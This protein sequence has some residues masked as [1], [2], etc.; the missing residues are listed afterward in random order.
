[1]RGNGLKLHQGRFILGTRENFCTERVAGDQNKAPRDVLKSPS[2]DMALVGMEMLGEKLNSQ[3]L[4]IF[5]SLHDWCS[6]L[7]WLPK[8]G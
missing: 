2:A 1:M 6:W 5:S 8:K 7:K 4:E 3:I